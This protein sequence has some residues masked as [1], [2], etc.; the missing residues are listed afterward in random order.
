M[1]R[2]LV[3]PVLALVAAGCASI[4]TSK[5]FSDRPL[6]EAKVTGK[7]YDPAVS[8]SASSDAD[9]VRVTLTSVSSCDRTTFRTVRRTQKIRRTVSTFTQ[10]LEYG[11]GVV[12]FGA[13]GYVAL[14]NRGRDEGQDTKPFDV[15]NPKVATIA[16][17]STAGLGGLLLLAGVI[18]SFRARDGAKDLGETRIPVPGSHAT[19]ACDEQPAAGVE[20]QIVAGKSRLTIGRTG[21]NGTLKLG[22][23]ALPANMQSSSGKGVV[24]AGPTRIGEIDL[25]GARGAAMDEAWAAAET[26]GT[27]EAY[28]AFRRSYPDAHPEAD[29]RIRELRVKEIEVA[30]ASA[31]AAGDFA[32]ARVLLDEWRTIDPGSA[33]LKTKSDEVRLAELRAGKD[34]AWSR[35]DALLLAAAAKDAPPSAMRE[36]L[37]QLAAVQSI[38]AD[39]PRLEDV[40]KKAAALTKTHMKRLVAS[41]GK[42]DK[43]REE[44]LLDAALADA[45]AIAPGDKAVGKLRIKIELRRQRDLAKAEKLAGA[46]DKKA[47]ALAAKEEKKRLAAEKK[48]EK[49]AAL[50]AAKEERARIAAEKKAEK[51]R[52]AA[53]KKAERERLAAEKKAAKE[54]ASANKQTEKERLAAEKQAEKERLAAEKEAE[55]ERIAAEK[56][57]KERIAQDKKVAAMTPSLAYT[58]DPRFKDD[59]ILGRMPYPDACAVALGGGQSRADVRCP[60]YSVLITKKGLD[61]QA[62]CTGRSCAQCSDLMTKWMA[63]FSKSNG[64][65]TRLAKSCE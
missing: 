28:E 19:V 1:V 15:A 4:H 3:I 60:G 23:A 11:F 16:G 45:E 55:K 26:A 56:A 50:A 12:F 57:E 49:A 31:Q 59:N 61:V 37:A 38:D 8:G 7:P 2:R 39:D 9:G 58:L 42:L 25:A 14:E 29:T 52:L 18:D 62:T 64:P 65:E 63:P 13:G 32:A 53:E 5:T 10:V 41:I 22:W 36:L 54:Q 48:A 51:A 24:W 35:L 17:Y 43:Q 27:R 20:V 44:A 21:A 40:R 6:S 34:V 46:G 33:A 30:L 47:E